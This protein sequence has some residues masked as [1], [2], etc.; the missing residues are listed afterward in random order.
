[1]GLVPIVLGDLF[2][3][4]GEVDEALFSETLALFREA[5]AAI[6]PWALLGN[7]DQLRAAEPVTAPL[8]RLAQAGVLT[9][10][11]QAGPQFWLEHDGP[12]SPGACL[13]GASPWDTALPTAVDT[14][15]AAA[16][17]HTVLWLT[18]HAIA[19]PDL[20]HF[21]VVPHEIP[22]VDWVINGHKHR[23]QPV[24]TVGRTRWAN[25]GGMMRMKWLPRNRSRRPSV[26]IWTPE[27]DWLQ[28]WELPYRPFSEVFPVEEPPDQI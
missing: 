27:R 26:V 12:V 28:A 3:Y 17:P 14:G 5:A 2:H 22:G 8:D 4:P 15:S 18:H 9:L 1:M 21:L 20:R 23:P 19:F 11:D 16:T 25:P 24:L 13:V 7:H 10:M 6:R